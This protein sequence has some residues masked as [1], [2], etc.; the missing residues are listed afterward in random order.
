ML[1][2]FWGFPGGSD[3]KESAYNAGDPVLFPGL[4]RSSGEGND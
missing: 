4:E 2:R 3:S 1:G